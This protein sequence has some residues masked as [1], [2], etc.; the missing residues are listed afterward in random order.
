M[1]KQ[2]SGREKKQAKSIRNIGGGA[3]RWVIKNGLFFDQ[4]NKVYVKRCRQCG[5][6]FGAKMPNALT[7]S[8]ACRQRR[9]RKV[10]GVPVGTLL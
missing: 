9:K 1:K 6:L 3:G 2:G 10:A 4:Q 5:V 7:C 8:D